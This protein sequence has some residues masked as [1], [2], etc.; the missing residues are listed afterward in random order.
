M[1]YVAKNPTGAATLYAD[2]TEVRD[3]ANIGRNSYLARSKSERMPAFVALAKST[4]GV[5]AENMDG[6]TTERALEA[7]GLNYTVQF[8]GSP[9]VTLMDDNGVE[10]VVADHL[11][12][13][14]AT[15]PN[16]EKP[17]A[18]FGTVGSIYQIFQPYQLADLGQE[19]INTGGANCIAAGAYGS[20]LYSR[21]YLAFKLPETI[22][23]GG[24]DPVDM[25]LT[26]GASHDGSTSAWGTIAPIRLDCTNQQTM[27]FGRLANRFTF[28]HSGDMGNK[29]QRMAEVLNI[30]DSW[31]T[32]FESACNT[33]LGTRMSDADLVSFVEKAL[34]TP[35][36]T[37]T[38]TGQRVWADRR[39]EIVALAR[40]AETCEFGRGTAY[41]AYQAFTEWTDWYRPARNEAKDPSARYS[42]VVNGDEG[43]K[44]KIRAADLLLV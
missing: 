33:M 34:P 42:R 14:V 23:V 32:E 24:V 4:G 1:G 17:P 9:R 15:W 38:E 44:W 3:I 10:D 22:M 27:T 40:E 19:A 13:T 41:A 16:R 36:G 26:L 2:G 25:Y 21:M 35:A 20:P 11:R 28:R 6:M 12:A 29:A 18:F 8:A 39:Q 43:E 31:A 37:G 5:Y 30:S 7:A